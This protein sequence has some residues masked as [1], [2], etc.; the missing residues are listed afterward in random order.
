MSAEGGNGP[1]G[2]VRGLVSLYTSTPN[3]GRAASASETDLFHYNCQGFHD[4]GWGCS[5]RCCQMVVSNLILQGII[6]PEPVKPFPLVTDIILAL[7]KRM[8]ACG[9][10]EWIEPPDIAKFMKITYNISGPLGEFR[11]HPQS[12]GN[13]SVSNTVEEISAPALAARFY[14]HF[15]EHAT[16][17]CIDDRV[18]A[19]CVLAVKT[20]ENTPMLLVFDPHISAILDF[21]DFEEHCQGT[22][23]DDFEFRKFGWNPI[24]TFCGNKNWLVFYPHKI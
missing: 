2:V 6:P 13:M 18:Y 21:T 16:P 12:S 22:V 23:L 9:S 8:S 11:I 20:V 1:N 3:P 10:G 7:G 5:Y 15:K 19:Y 14:T 4:C 24:V 17:I